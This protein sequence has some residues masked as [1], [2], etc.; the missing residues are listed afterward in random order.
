LTAA[1]EGDSHR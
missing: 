1:S